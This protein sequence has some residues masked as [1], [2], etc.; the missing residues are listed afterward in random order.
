MTSEPVGG[1]CW[2]ASLSDADDDEGVEMD[3]C[4]VLP[5]A[6]RPKLPQ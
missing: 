3:L 2:S 6:L 4:K 5:G 1:A